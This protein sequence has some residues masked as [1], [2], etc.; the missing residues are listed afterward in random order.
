[1]AIPLG[2]PREKEYRAKARGFEN[3]ALFSDMERAARFESCDWE[4][5]IREGGVIEMRIPK[6]QGRTYLWTAAISQGANGDCRG[7]V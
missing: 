2:D 3:R 6:C 5:P 4:L 1:M 7:K